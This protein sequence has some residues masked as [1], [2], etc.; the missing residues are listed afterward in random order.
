MV[1]TWCL[2][3]VAAAL[4]GCEPATF[5]TDLEGQA[6][7]EGDPTPISDVLGALPAIGSFTNMD[8]DANQDF[9]NQGVTKEQV[10]SVRVASLTLRIVDPSGQDFG[11]LDQIGFYAKV[12]DSEAKVADKADVAALGLRA[13]NPTLALDVENVELQPFVTA[14]AMSIVMRGSG[15]MPPQDTRIEVVVRLKVGVKLLSL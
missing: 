2:V 12:G 11:F 9:R 4:A 8:F 13:P 6:T 10:G 7:V 3:A 15:R 5:Y 1:R 14:R